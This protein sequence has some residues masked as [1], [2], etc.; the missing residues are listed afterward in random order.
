MS[1]TQEQQH[2]RISDVAAD[3]HELTVS[4]RIMRPSVA[5]ATDNW[6]RGAASR[7][8][9][10]PISHTRP[11]PRSLVLR[12]LLLIPISLRVGG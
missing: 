2:F 11:S 7:H 10:A 9:T 8:T 5:R 6:T 4:Q 12:K 1:Q 3:W